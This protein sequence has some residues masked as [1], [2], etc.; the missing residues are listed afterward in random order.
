MKQ[1]EESF[2]SSFIANAV[3][4]AFSSYTAIMLNSVTIYAIR[5]TSSL[6]KPLKTLLLSV[7]VADLGVGL[8]VQPFIIA[9]LIKLLQ[10]NTTL[11]YS[12]L[13]A[14][15]F[16]QCLFFY[17]SFFGVVVII[18]DRYLSI[19]LH[20]RYQELVTHKRAVA[21]VISIWIVS[22]VL[23]ISQLWLSPQEK[24]YIDLVL[25]IIFGFCFL[26][27]TFFNSRIYFTLRRHRN[28]M[29]VLQAQ[30]VPQNDHLDTIAR[31][32][33]S[34]VSTFYIYLVFIV[35]CLPEYC[36]LVVT[37][38]LAPTSAFMT[39]IYLYTWTMVFV[40]SSLNPVIYC[41]KM[42]HIRHSILGILRD[43]F[44]RQNWTSGCSNQRGN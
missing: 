9:L 43:I 1:A 39:V 15:S 24:I 8:L 11:P 37:L 18:T 28:Q 32:R 40:N 44:P 41:W 3:L 6:P 22:A 23:S 13:T 21:V 12:T 16:F 17:A 19:H 10:Q 34:A 5:R 33:K 31:L 7:A 29:R 4:N 35:C 26:C 2:Y 25:A 27:T 20:L 14:F 36:R 42:R 38:I 30:Q